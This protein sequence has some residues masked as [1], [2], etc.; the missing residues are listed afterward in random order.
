VLIFVLT[1]CKTKEIKI[2]DNVFAIVK[3]ESGEGEQRVVTFSIIEGTVKKVQ[4]YNGVLEYI[5]ADKSILTPDNPVQSEYVFLNY[6][7]ALKKLKKLKDKSPTPID[8]NSIPKSGAF[9]IPKTSLVS[10]SLPNFQNTGA[11]CKKA[12]ERRKQKLWKNL[13][14]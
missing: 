2:G 1:G 8:N 7:D 10:D 12:N 3:Y 13:S 6:E 14:N 4:T 11:P 9:I 5:I